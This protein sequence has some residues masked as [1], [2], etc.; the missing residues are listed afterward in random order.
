MLPLFWSAAYNWVAPVE[1]FPI[2]SPV[3]EAPATVVSIVDFAPP[4]HPEIEP[5]RL[6]KMKAALEVP[7]GK[8]VEP[9]VIPGALVFTWPVGPLVMLGPDGGAPP[10]VATPTVSSGP[11]LVGICVSLTL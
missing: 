10:W 1:V 6:A 8:S 4:F 7:T 9:V 3:K 2:A 5:S 11:E